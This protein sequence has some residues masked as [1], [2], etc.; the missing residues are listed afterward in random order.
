MIGMGG[1]T[2]AQFNCKTGIEADNFF[3]N[4]VEAWRA[5]MDLTDF[6]LI[7]HS[8]GGYT[9]SIYAH[10]Y[11]QHVKK[12][13]LVSP[14]GYTYEPPNFCFDNVRHKNGKQPPGLAHTVVGNMWGT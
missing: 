2:R 12:L 4:F 7:G 3:I 1:S 9:S 14:I 11:P 10:R 5:K 13:I 8:Y 6:Y